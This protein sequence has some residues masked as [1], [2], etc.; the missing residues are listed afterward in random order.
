M[1]TD[2][3]LSPSLPDAI[4]QVSPESEQDP[5]VE[6]L[7]L[8]AL[9]FTDNCQIQDSGLGNTVDPRGVVIAGGGTH[10]LLSPLLSDGTMQV[11]RESGQNLSVSYLN[12]LFTL[13]FC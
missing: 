7:K 5:S 4:I 2:S 13:G 8:S 10:S 1:A 3:P 11:S 6:S 9:G 12:G